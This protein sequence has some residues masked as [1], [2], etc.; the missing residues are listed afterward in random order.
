[1]LIQDDRSGTTSTACCSNCRQKPAIGFL[2]LSKKLSIP[3]AAK[4]INDRSVGSWFAGRR[5]N[6]PIMSSG[7]RGRAGMILAFRLRRVARCRQRKVLK[8]YCA[9]GAGPLPPLRKYHDRP[10]FAIIR[11]IRQCRM[12][13][14]PAW[15]SLRSS[16]SC[17]PPTLDKLLPLFR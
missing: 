6:L 5:H 16:L 10:H 2:R 13:R 4:Q 3:Y 15:F 14:L 12:K 11:I 9:A 7:M 17:L 8:R 1:M